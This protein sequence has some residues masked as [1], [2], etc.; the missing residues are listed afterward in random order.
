METGTVCAFDLWNAHIWHLAIYFVKPANEKRDILREPG[1]RL[2]FDYGIEMPTKSLFYSAS[3]YYYFEDK[4]NS[5]EN[6]SILCL[7]KEL[8]M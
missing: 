1:N 6:K 3:L 8:I 2:Y 4:M 5:I 7:S